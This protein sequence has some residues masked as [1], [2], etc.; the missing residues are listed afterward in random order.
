[1]HF[2]WPMRIPCSLVFRFAGRNTPG[3]VGRISRVVTRCLCDDRKKAFHSFVL[4]MA[5]LGL[6]PVSSVFFKLLY[7]ITYFHDSMFRKVGF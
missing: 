3:K 1:M 6:H 2:D 5:S 7:D 4:P